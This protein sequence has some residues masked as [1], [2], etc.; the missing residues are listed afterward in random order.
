MNEKRTALIGIAFGLGAGIA[1]G[2]CNV[3]IKYS[4]G[5]ISTPL[6]GAAVSL[7]IGTVCLSVF[8]MR[9]IR[10]DL[11]KNRKGLVYM[12]MAGLAAS[13]GIVASFFALSMAPV[14]VIS[15]LQGTNPLFALLFSWLFLGRLEKITVRI[16]LGTVLIVGGVILITLGRVA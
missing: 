3:L 11:V 13:C 1:Y 9:G 7:L 8:G 12:L 6:V 4:V 2:V 5:E 14:V 10:T 16:I 15:P